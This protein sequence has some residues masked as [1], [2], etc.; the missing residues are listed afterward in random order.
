MW[1]FLF[2]YLFGRATG[3]S[4]IVRPLLWLFLI[5]VIVA[6]FIYAAVVFKA[7]SERSEQH[8]VHTHSTH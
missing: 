2:G 3:I 8:H 4:R 7:V 6:G 1:D 5:G